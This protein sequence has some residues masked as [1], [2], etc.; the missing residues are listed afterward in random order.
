MKRI[1]KALAQLYPAEW[2]RRYGAEYEALLEEGQPR[3]RDIF[4]V[5]REAAK[6]QLTSWS[7]VRIVLPCALTG[8]LAASLITVV[9]PSQLMSLRG[10]RRF[11]GGLR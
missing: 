7:F 2:R 5:L 1:L 11:A 8:I 4:D 10:Q 9:S 6:M 3:L